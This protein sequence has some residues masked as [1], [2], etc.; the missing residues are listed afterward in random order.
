M[1]EFT[2]EMGRGAHLRFRELSDRISVEP[3]NIPTTHLKGSLSSEDYSS[4]EGAG[5]VLLMPEVSCMV[6][7]V[8]ECYVGILP[9]PGG[10]SPLTCQ[11][12]P[13]CQPKL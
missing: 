3:M 11:K 1:T 6:S 12:H 4:Q 9:L 8:L 2:L 10:R 5:A 13:P 7:N